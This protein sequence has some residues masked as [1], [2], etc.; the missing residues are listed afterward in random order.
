MKP[1]GVVLD[2]TVGLGGH[3]EAILEKIGPEGRLIALDRDLEAMDQARARL[4]RFAGRVEWIHGPFGEMDRFLAERGV[5]RLDAAVFD[6][7]VSSLQLDEARR[8]FSFQREGPLDMR[9][10]PED[11]L[12]A[13][14]IVNRASQG[15]IQTILQD[16]GQ[17][18]FA[19]RIARA[20]VRARPLSTTS[21]LA[22]VVRQAVPP[23]GRHGRIHPATRTFQALRISVNGELEQLSQGLL[24]AVDRLTA[25]GRVAVL[26]YH[27]LEDRIVKVFFRE[28]AK[29]GVLR[30]LTRKP[31]RPSPEEV[32]RNPRS[33]SACLRIAERL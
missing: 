18:R 20:I 15:E 32:E 10:N 7:G 31:L 6:L 28:Q 2:A 3:A 13:A 30:V 26:S 22:D 29:A 27:S 14:D 9:M 17:E 21:H 33:R 12:T 24:Q 19:G 5:G 11:S 1:G 4:E 23:A 8:G 16:W 25:G